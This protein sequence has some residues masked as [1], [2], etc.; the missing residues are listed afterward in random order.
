MA[1]C[2]VFSH[3]KILPAGILTLLVVVAA[4]V[5]GALPFAD[6]VA[7]WQMT[8]SHDSAEGDP[9]RAWNRGRIYRCTVCEDEVRVSY[10]DPSPTEGARTPPAP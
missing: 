5:F 7:V 2:V 4:P 6:A 9:E 3:I 1:F 10:A 8:D